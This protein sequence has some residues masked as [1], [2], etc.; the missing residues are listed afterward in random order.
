MTELIKNHWAEII[1]AVMAFVKVVV[2][3][4]PTEKDNKIFSFVDTIINWVIPNRKKGG[5]VH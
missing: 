5:G 2:N 1:L 3:L 4:T